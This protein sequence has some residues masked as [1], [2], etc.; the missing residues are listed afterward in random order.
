[1]LELQCPGH[2]PKVDGL[3]VAART[4]KKASIWSFELAYE[5]GG[6]VK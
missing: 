6:Y 4:L 2:M 5:D 1:M 3:Y